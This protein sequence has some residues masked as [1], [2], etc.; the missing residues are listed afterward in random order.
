MTAAELEW[1]R[2]VNTSPAAAVIITIP[3]LLWVPAPVPYMLPATGAS[4]W[5]SAN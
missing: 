4:F 5:N 1:F 2:T 3:L